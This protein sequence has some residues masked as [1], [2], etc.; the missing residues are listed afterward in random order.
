MA[1]PEKIFENKIKKF[2]E[3][4][5]IF[6]IGAAN[7]KGI[8]N[9]YYEKRWGGGT[10]TRSGL[11]DLHISVLGKSVEVEIKAENGKLSE[12]QKRNLEQINKSGG[13]GLVIFPKDFEDFKKVILNIINEQ[14][15][16]KNYD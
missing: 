11:P 9:G 6:P 3:Q 1:G 4:N 5:Y 14:K 15:G 16:T 2:L 13:C 10:F 12:L 7:I 8:Q